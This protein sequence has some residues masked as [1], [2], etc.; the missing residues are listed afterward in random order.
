MT[1]I[2]DCEEQVMTVVWESS[3]APDLSA[4]RSAVNEK[5][6]HEWAPQTVS[7]FL[8]RLVTKEYL[9]PE[10]KGRY[11]YYHVAISVEGYR[12]QRLKETVDMLFGGDKS[13]VVECLN[14]I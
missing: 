6:G 2:S 7:T 5:Y 14:H 10:R 9:V 3:E 13:K 12:E 4:V 8:S 11:T 1:K